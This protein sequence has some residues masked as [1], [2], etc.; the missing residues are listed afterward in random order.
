MEELDFLLALLFILFTL[1]VDESLD[2]VYL[3]VLLDNLL[4]LLLLSLFKL[5]LFLLELS[6]SMLGLQLLAHCK[7]Y[8][9]KRKQQ[10]MQVRVC[11]IWLLSVLR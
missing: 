6:A 3:G 9:A 10:Y 11:S 8:R 7:S 2:R 5:N 1:L 4:F